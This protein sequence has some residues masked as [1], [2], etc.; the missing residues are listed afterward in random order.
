M[1][2]YF[3]YDVSQVLSD[4]TIG[5]LSA[6]SCVLLTY[7]FHCVIFFL[8]DFTCWNYI[9]LQAHFIYFLCKFPVLKSATYL[10]RP[11]PFFRE[12]S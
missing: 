9:I 11:V 6:D 12:W 3:I 4:L 2:Y 5:T 1:K 7:P 10:K 8:A